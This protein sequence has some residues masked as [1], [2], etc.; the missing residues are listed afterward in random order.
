MVQDGKVPSF[1]C[2]VT[3][4]RSDVKILPTS[5]KLTGEKACTGP[6][7]GIKPDHSYEVAVFA[8]NSKDRGSANLQTC[9]TLR[10][11]ATPV[12]S[13]KSLVDT[14]PCG[15]EDLKTWPWPT[16]D[17]NLETL[18][19]D[20]LKKIFEETRK[21]RGRPKLKALSLDNN[22]A[23]VNHSYASLNTETSNIT[24]GQS[25]N[26]SE[27]ESGTI[28]GSLR[29]CPGTKSTIGNS[30]IQVGL[31]SALKTY[32]EGKIACLIDDS[33]LLQP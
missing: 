24:V 14:I 18:T 1:G 21:P 2:P 25:G 32:G 27:I 5:S 6:F 23:T 13:L 15:A 11:L 20:Q 28:T 29:H 17:P 10:E 12:P 7:T 22:T 4:L 3:G 26:N 31:N 30:E 16:R 9:L 8:S 33:Y 19:S